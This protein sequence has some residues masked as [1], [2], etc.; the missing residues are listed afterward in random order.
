MNKFSL[1]V[2]TALLTAPASMAQAEP[3]P[4]PN[5]EFNMFKPGSNYT[6]MA[7][8]G[9]GNSFARGVGD[10][11]ELAGGTVVY[12]DGSP[13][14]MTGDGIP[15]IDMPGWAPLNSGNDLFGNGVGGSNGMNLFGSWGG[16]GRIQS[17]ASLGP[18]KSG[19]I[20]TIKIMIGGPDAGPIGG[21]LAFH[22]AA[23]GV[24]LIPSE[25][26]EPTLPNGGAF[27]EISRTYD[28]DAVAAHIGAEMTIIIGVEDTNELGNRVVFDNVSMEVLRTGPPPRIPLMITPGVEGAGTYDFTWNSQDGKIY[29]LV[30]STNLSIPLPEWPVYDGNAALTATAPENMLIAIP[31]NGAIRFFA[32]I[33]KDPPP[34]LREDFEGVAGPGAPAGWLASDNGAGTAWQVGTPSGAATGPGAAANGT[35]CAGTNIGGDYTGSAEAS[36]ITSA[37]TVPASGATLTFNQYVDTEAPPSGDLGSIRLLNAADDSILAGGDVATGLEGITEAWS[38]QSLPLPAAANGLEVKL[39]FRFTSDTDVETFA[40]FYIDDVVVTA[41]AP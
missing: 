16:Q 25:S 35:R 17:A 32:V 8:F 21:P 13:P 38:A 40:G 28:T 41:T 19:S 39:E 5:G 11:I 14:G 33:E 27:Q 6:V 31:G 36:L 23:D 24:P 7:T 2:L 37:F 26:V 29:D 22:L 3:I 18:I 1:A 30:S 12:S 20:Y 10:N 9:G 34:L 15:D 4:V